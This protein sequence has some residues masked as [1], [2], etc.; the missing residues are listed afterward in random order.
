MQPLFHSSFAGGE[1]ILPVAAVEPRF[2]LGVSLFA[3]RPFLSR[4][5][6]IAGSK[7]VIWRKG[8]RDEA[9]FNEPPMRS[10]QHDC[11]TLF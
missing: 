1:Q 5:L 4:R 3:L 8:N 7:L 11:R 9:A 10:I 2:S 6:R